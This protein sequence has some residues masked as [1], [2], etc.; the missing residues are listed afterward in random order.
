M[1][2]GTDDDLVVGLCI[3]M[4]LVPM[5]APTPTPI[6]HPFL[7]TVGDPS[8]KAA[9]AVVQPMKAAGGELEED[10][11]L[12][13]NGIIVT[14]V[15]TITKNTSALPHMPLPPGTGWA[16]M[17]KAPKPMVGILEE[18]PPPDLPVSPAGDA[19]MDKGSGAVNFGKGAVVRLGD[20]CASCSEPAR[21]V[22]T[23]IAIPKGPP[24][25]VTG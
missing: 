1:I 22:S 7:A 12:N 16:P 3:H 23:F 15:G 24:V 21:Q 18:P 19:L 9:Q 17:P 14:N 25:L 5:P 13:V 2:A 20:P 11:P 10:R 6:P 8:R 4:E